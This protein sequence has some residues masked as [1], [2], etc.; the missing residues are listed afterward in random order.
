[1]GDLTKAF[2]D[3]AQECADAAVP[4]RLGAEARQPPSI[5]P[6]R[7]LD[8][9]EMVQCCLYRAG[10]RHVTSDSGHQTPTA[11]YDG[12]W[13]QWQEAHHISVADAKKTPG[14]LVF[15]QNNRKKPH[16][17][18]HVGISDGQGHIIEAS[19]GAGKVVR[20]KW[21]KPDLAAK[22]PELYP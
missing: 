6:P 13:L 17:I 9:S 19:S 20:R 16:R 11:V 14:A 8:C 1:M 15:W 4:Y 10:V 18:G 5:W 22:V 21:R 2:L 7:A 3:A 12:A